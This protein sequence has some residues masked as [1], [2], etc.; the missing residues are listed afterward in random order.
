MRDYQKEAIN[1]AFTTKRGILQL[2]TGAGKTLLSSGLIQRFGV[3]TLFLVHTKDLLYQAYNVFKSVFSDAKIGIIGDGNV[4]LGDIV[5]AT[6]QT[7]EPKIPY[8]DSNYGDTKYDIDDNY[9][10]EDIVLIKTEKP[11]NVST[12]LV[13]EL[14]QST[15]LLIVDECL[16]ENT[17]IGL[18]N[19]LFKQIKDIH[20]GDEIVGGIVSNKFEKETDKIVKIRTLFGEL[21]A[22]ETHPHFVVENLP[23]KNR[24][25]WNPNESD[26][27]IK[28]S[29]ELQVGNYLLIPDQLDHPKLEKNYDNDLLYFVAFVIGDGHLDKREHS[30]Q[31]KFE[32]H[33]QEKCDIIELIFQKILLNIDSSCVVKTKASVRTD[34]KNFDEYWKKTI[35]CNSKVLRSVLINDFSIPIGKKSNDIIIN[36]NILN[37]PLESLKSFVQGCFDSEGWV[38]TKHKRIGIGYTSLLF[39]KQLQLILLKFGIKSKIYERKR[40][41]PIHKSLFMLDI[42]GEDL[43]KYG[44]KIGF[45]LPSKHQKMEEILKNIPNRTNNH[46]VNYNGMQYWLS[47]IEEIKTIETPTKVYDFTTTDHSFIANGFLT[48]NCQHVPAQTMYKVVTKVNS[49]YKFGLSATP[50]RDDGFQL[51]IEAGLG[52]IIFKLSASTLIDQGYLVQP[53]IKCI[54]VPQKIIPVR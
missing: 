39:I 51:K 53:Q 1:T 10:E 44:N 37:N 45:N 43:I 50:Y 42:T 46:Y 4:E 29:N 28:K 26:I 40:K 27:I 12:D 6:I 30:N 17:L 11:T 20:N 5:I 7:L 52:K 21:E 9:T 54:R 48:H 35:W 33:N 49:P 31:L 2:A 32:F 36:N 15:K 24:Q 19:G 25:Y 18:K 41:N 22:S 34:I 13:L 3:K 8:N 38:V 23:Y 14:L 47:R 16:T